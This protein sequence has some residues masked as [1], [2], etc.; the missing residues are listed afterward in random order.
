MI[1]ESVAGAAGSDPSNASFPM[2]GTGPPTRSGVDFTLGVA[3]DAATLVVTAHGLV[4]VFLNGARV[5]DDELVPGFTSY[6]K[7]LQVFTYDVAGL[8]RPGANRVE[9]LLSDG[10]FRGRHGFE[11]RPD[12]FG[13]ETALLLAIEAGAVARRDG[14]LVAVASEPHHP[15]R[16]HGRAGS[17][18]PA[19]RRRPTV[20]AGHRR[21]GR[22]LRRPRSAGRGIRCPRAPRSRRSRLPPCHA[23][24]T[25]GTV[26]VDVGR[27]INGWLRIDDLGPRDTHLTLTHGEVLD[28]DGLVSMENLRA[29]VFATGERLPA[30]QVDEVISAGRAGDVFEPRHTTH[31]FRYVQ[32]DGVPSGWDA[33]AVRAVVVHSDLRPVGEF[34]CSDERLNALHELARRSFL[35]NA[36]DI[37]TDCPQR[38][39]S[40]FTGDWQVFVDAAAMLYDVE[41]FSAK[42]LDDLA[43]DQWADGRVPTVIP[44]PAG[45]GPSGVV[46][47]DMSAGSAG[48][49]DAAVLVPW[50]LW[51]HYGDL[52]ALRGACRRCGGG[53]S[54]R[55][56]RR[57][58]SRHPDRAAARPEA[59]PHEEFLWDTGFHFGEW[60][61]PGVPPRPDPTVD[62]SIVATAFLHRSARLLAA[63]A[64]LVGDD[65]PRRLGERRRRWCARRVARRSSSSRPGRLSIESQAN[66][67]RGLAFELF[68]ATEAAAGGRPTRRAH[69]R[70]RRSPRH[71]L[72]QHRTAA[73]RARRSRPGRRRVRDAAVDRASHH[74]SACSSTARRPRGSGGTR[75]ATTA[76]CAA[77]STTTARP[78]SSRSST[79]T[80]PA[81]VSMRFRMPRPPHSAACASRP[82]RAAA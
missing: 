80:S 48:W 81:S 25:E 31:G 43:A 72:P 64:A 23:P 30:G 39:R 33:S 76:P 68:D 35:G 36:C 82:S 15:R 50:E 28:A 20:D 5:G 24:A 38:E 13:D 53:S 47:E 73:A 34:A 21:D 4:E 44:N 40:G 62:H 3:P 70:G 63:S 32:I 29:F 8:L 1:A 12:G 19:C 22:A 6:R 74:G 77:R 26:V 37:P 56:A 16:P 45:D 52:D 42:W 69:R 54:T 79:R 55:R 9:V 49:G 75:S 65:E 2:P 60:L 10:W 71:R 41:A 59:A 61:E 18:L 17:R 11:R 67:A 51:R 14:C 58:A 78:R 27:N 66:Y 57:P 46:F 7:R